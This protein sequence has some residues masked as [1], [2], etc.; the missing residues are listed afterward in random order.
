MKKILA[1]AF[2]PYWKGGKQTSGLATGIFDLHDAVN[3]LHGEYE[4]VLACTDVNVEEKMVDS[5]KVIGWNSKLLI[6]HCLKRFYRLPYFL[7]NTLRLKNNYHYPFASTFV[8]SLFL[9][10][11]V[12]KEKPDAIHFHGITNA[13]YIKLLWHK[14]LPA[15]L[16]LHGM[17]GYNDTVPGYLDYRK[18]EQDVITLPYKITTFISKKNQNDWN[19]YYGK[20]SC[21]SEVVLN[22]YNSSLFYWD[23]SDA[24]IEKEYDLITIAAIDENKGQIRVLEALN[25]LKK[26]GVKLKYLVIGSGQEKYVNYIQEYAKNNNL[27]VTFQPHVNQSKLRDFIVN[28]RYFILPSAAEGFGKVFVESLACGTPVILPKDLPIVQEGLLSRDNSILMD[29]ESTS[30]IKVTLQRLEEFKLT[31]SEQISKTV[32]Q[33]SWKNAAIKYCKI[34]RSNGI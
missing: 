10:Y 27:D 25:E 24:N 13:Y 33:L 34:Y 11:A 20:F 7:L 15:I 8:K 23:E 12:E 5:T 17:N 4:V 2:L 21:P 31:S 28:S 22:G 18:K 32:S 9:D 29:D 3:S 30:S 14:K 1:L 19:Q 26:Q 6:K 16:R